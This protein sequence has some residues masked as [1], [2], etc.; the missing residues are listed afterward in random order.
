[1]HSHPVVLDVW[2]L[3]GPYF[4]WTAKA[5]ARLCLWAFA[6]R[7]CDKYLNL[8]SS[9]KFRNN[10]IPCR[11][12]QGLV[13]YIRIDTWLT[14]RT[15]TLYL[16]YLEYISHFLL[17]S[18]FLSRHGWKTIYKKFSIYK[19]VRSDQIRVLTFFLDS[20]D[21]RQVVRISKQVAQRATIAHLSPMCRHPLIS[22]K[23][24]SKVIKNLNSIQIREQLFFQGLVPP[25]SAVWTCQKSNLL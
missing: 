18:Y 6:G 13:T 8:M 19:I 3:A 23:P 17:R 7:L 9:W 11:K 12:L 2:F 14:E 25:M 24:A 1:M 22:N 20:W 4:T 15:T 5:L 10:Q 21:R 16:H